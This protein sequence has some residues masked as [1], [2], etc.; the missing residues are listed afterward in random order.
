M[1]RMS[2]VDNTAANKSIF[3]LYCPA[4]RLN[5]P[6]VLLQRALAT[7]SLYMPT[8]NEHAVV[9]VWF[10]A[11]YFHSVKV[12][13][14]TRVHQHTNCSQT[15][16]LF[17]CFWHN[18]PTRAMANSFTRFLDHTQ[19]RTIVGR[20]PLDEWSARRRGLYL[21]IH[22]TLTIMLW[23]VHV[24]FAVLSASHTQHSEQYTVHCVQ[25]DSHSTQRTVHSSLCSA[26]LTLNTAN[27]T[28]THTHTHHT[29]DMLSTTA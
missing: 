20:T 11:P 18:N 26:W 13:A 3:L 27:S 9:I 1:H 16:C 17:V 6:N 12:L 29:Y 24:L 4:W 28:H 8:I 10:V 22:T 5:H 23:Y 25:R 7:V 2:F 15:D 19:R 14:T 21:T